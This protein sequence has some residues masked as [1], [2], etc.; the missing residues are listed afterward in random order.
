MHHLI[1]GYKL[2]AVFR[3]LGARGNLGQH[4]RYLREVLPRGDVNCGD[5]IKSLWSAGLRVKKSRLAG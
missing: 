2:G 5:H 1:D 4:L 3:E